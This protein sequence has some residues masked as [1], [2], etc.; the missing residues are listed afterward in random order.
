RLNAELAREVC[1]V[2]DAV[3]ATFRGATTAAFPARESG[4]PPVRGTLEGVVLD[5]NPAS[6]SKSAIAAHEAE[7]QR[8]AEYAGMAVVHSQE[9]DVLLIDTIEPEGRS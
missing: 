2:G 3:H 1:G 9:R 6:I 7:A 8:F 4:A 5:V